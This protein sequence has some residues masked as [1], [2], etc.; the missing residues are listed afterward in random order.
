MDCNNLFNDFNSKIKL[1]RAKKVELRK[2]RS[3]LRKAIK[4]Y[5]KDKKYSIPYFYS[6]GSFALNTN[7]NPISNVVNGVTKVEYDLDDGVYFICPKD[8]RLT[9]QSYHDRIVKAVKEH[10]SDFKDKATC[11]RAIYSD[12]HHVDLPVY[13]LEEKG[14]T[15]QLAHK[16]DEFIES[17][18]KAFKDWCEAKV[19]ETSNP[20][21]V[22][23]LI[24][25]LKAWRDH[26]QHSNTRIKLLSGFV[27]TILVVDH[28]SDNDRDDLSLK[29]TVENIYSSLTSKYECF[30]P[31]VPENEDLLLKYNKDVTLDELERFVV[32]AKKATEEEEC[33]KKASEQW[34]VLFG[35]RF[36]LGEE[37]PKKAK[38]DFAT[39]RQSFAPA[40]PLWLSS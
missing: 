32:Y 25:Y 23:R 33:Q 26:R 31:T 35:D 10:T 20:K 6:Q 7:I 2:N 24:R 3:G 5:F 14:D 8:D 39:P 28:Y 15:P 1:T 17:D 34:K 18:P 4:K 12:G 9:A 11:V 30:R 37:A 22:K 40:N 13:W 21:Q 27:L 36:K 29:D 16:I 38:K 19:S